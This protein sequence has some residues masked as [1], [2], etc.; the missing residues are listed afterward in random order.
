[1]RSRK[2]SIKYIQSASRVHRR[3][4]MLSGAQLLA[5]I[6]LFEAT[7]RVKSALSLP[8]CT[9]HSFAFYRRFGT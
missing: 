8:H 9:G 2:V 1:M 3:T 5:D 6:I 7:R 4:G